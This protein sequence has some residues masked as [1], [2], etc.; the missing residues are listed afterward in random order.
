MFNR[1]L[2]SII[3]TFLMTSFLS[4]SKSSDELR[5][6]AI[7]SASIYL[8]KHQCNEAIDVLE[9]VGRRTKHARYMQTL[10]S[11]YACKSGYSTPVFYGVNLSKIAATE[12][13]LLG[14]LTT[15]TTSVITGP[16]H[17]TYTN[18]QKAIDILLY[19][20]DVE[21]P[22]TEAREV[23]FTVDEVTD[24]NI[25]ALYMILTQLGKYIFYY[26][27]ADPTLGRKGTGSEANGNPNN[28]SNGCFYDYEFVDQDI[29]T[30]VDAE[31]AANNLG[32]CTTLA[33]GNPALPELPDDV[34]VLRMCQGIILFNQLIDIVLNTELPQDAGDLN[35]LADIFDSI[36]STLPGGL[37]NI[38]TEKSQSACEI[39]YGVTPETDR[40]QLYYFAIFEKLFL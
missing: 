11:A 25:Q 40:L 34:T 33:T 16:V 18:L 35:E 8:T 20:G 19:A 31:R 27:N 38:V 21:L 10:A 4:C 5:D 30:L 28:L 24:M 15:F 1:L 14:S 37:G 7:E 22:T 23:I 12:E 39:N 29:Q 2:L 32:S 6:D 13:G 17:Y 9:S 36:I 3:I 26:G